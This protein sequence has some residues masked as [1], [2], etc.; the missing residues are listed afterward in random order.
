M[1]CT[2]GVLGTMVLRRIQP[3][4]FKSQLFAD[5]QGNPQPAGDDHNIALRKLSIRVERKRER[6][7]LLQVRRSHAMQTYLH[8]LRFVQE[9]VN[10]ISEAMQNPDKSSAA[11][12]PLHAAQL[13]QDGK[14][15][16]KQ[17][18]ELHKLES[19][20]MTLQ[21]SIAQ[22]EGEI[23]QR[24]V[25]LAQALHATAAS[26]SLPEDLSDGDDSNTECGSGS[27]SLE[28]RP[29]GYGRMLTVES[30]QLSCGLEH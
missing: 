17:S 13:V 30:S 22:S 4:D 8:K 28:I 9:S 21:H 19:A 3:E 1:V 29:S 16:E 20:C 23:R 25:I 2:D 14:S 12:Y 7:A 10:N 11:G 15:L 18:E 24:L 5:S 6:L 27:D 26:I